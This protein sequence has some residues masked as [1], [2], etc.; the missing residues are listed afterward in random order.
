MNTYE[1]KLFYKEI[2]KHESGNTNLAQIK[3]SKIENL[4]IN[5]FK[6]S[7]NMNEEYKTR[8]E[9][10]MSIHRRYFLAGISE[11]EEE[12][13][14]Y[15]AH[16]AATINVVEGHNKIL[17]KYNPVSEPKKLLKKLEELYGP[18]THISI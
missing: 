14:H 13:K 4:I 6:A 3:F 9:R 7:P 17:V 11:N 15:A 1:G 8:G 10:I 12:T 5:E 18:P 16:I 2:E